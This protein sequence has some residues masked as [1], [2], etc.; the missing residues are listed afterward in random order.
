MAKTWI[1]LCG[2]AALS[3]AL[4]GCGASEPATED[5]T[6]AATTQ[7]T[8]EPSPGTD[9]GT[10][11]TTLTSGDEMKFDG[12]LVSESF[13]ASGE[14]TLMLD[15]P[16]AG[17]LDGVIGA[18]LPAESASDPSSMLAALPEAPGFTLLATLQ[19][20]ETLTGLEGEYVVYVANPG[21]KPWTLLIR[22]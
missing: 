2:A 21:E 16:G 4:A 6:G 20:E 7:E 10:T 18:V 22:S 17:E 9:A 15:M 8:V 5:P 3:L 11:V 12:L 14:V 19:S 13:N 1:S